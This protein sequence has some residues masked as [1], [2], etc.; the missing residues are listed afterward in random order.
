[1]DVSHF[2]LFGTTI[3][4][5]DE[6]AR[7]KLNT[8]LGNITY[9]N[10]IGRI[11]CDNIKSNNSTPY[12][13]QGGTITNDGYAV[14]A[15]RT[16]D[17]TKVDLY[18]INLTN[19]NKTKYTY[20][21]NMGH[22]N[23][24]AFNP[25][26]GVLIVSD[27]EYSNTYHEISYPSMSYVSSHNNS[28]NTTWIWYNRE[29]KTYYAGTSNFVCKLDNEFNT[30]KKTNVIKPIS[31]TGQ[32][33]MVVNN[34]YY[35]LNYNPNIILMY[36]FDT[37]EFIKCLAFSDLINNMFNIGEPEW[38]DYYNNK[39]YCGCT[40]NGVDT[41]KNPTIHRICYFD[42]KSNIKEGVNSSFQG[43][44]TPVVY[45]SGDFIFN[46]DGSNDRPFYTIREASLLAMTKSNVGV[47]IIATKPYNE[48]YDIILKGMT[49]Y[50]LNTI[51]AHPTITMNGN[52]EIGRGTTVRMKQIIFANHCTFVTSSNAM[53]HIDTSNAN[54]FPQGV[55]MTLEPGTILTVTTKPLNDIF[56]SGNILSFQGC[57]VNCTNTDYPISYNIVDNCP[58]FTNQNFVK[59]F[60]ILAGKISNNN[61]NFTCQWFPIQFYIKWGNETFTIIRNVSS[62]SAGFECTGSND[63]SGNLEIKQ[64]SM[65]ISNTGITDFT[66]KLFTSFS[67]GNA[68]D[69]EALIIY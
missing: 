59:N 9:L 23:S 2:D 63:K 42:T 4:I 26:N 31:A 54:V 11:F 17:E 28:E 61:P 14:V 8:T 6:Y 51:T 47:E 27:T 41:S 1:M 30:I 53:V 45:V 10:Q 69:T 7:N 20:N 29:E 15:A 58:T 67:N 25:D 19:G 52:I 49:Y 36:D 55:N 65:Q 64:L 21:Q 39:F 24:I 57:T 43:N 35:H 66:A 50:A 68:D 60:P 40:E 5:K 48:N 37:G 32:T 3:N 33:G 62:T 38:I 44:D 18:K 16:A 56:K 12:L 46:P 22:A 13:W 34:I